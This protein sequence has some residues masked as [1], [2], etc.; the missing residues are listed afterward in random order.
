MFSYLGPLP[1]LSSFEVPDL[2][3]WMGG[4]EMLKASCQLQQVLIGE[5]DGELG[6]RGGQGWEKV[7][8]D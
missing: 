6:R 4:K 1:P 7:A 5:R 2:H 8:K 3:F